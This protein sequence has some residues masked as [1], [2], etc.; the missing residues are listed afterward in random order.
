M[1]SPAMTEPEERALLDV[2]DLRVLDGEG[3]ELLS[4]LSFSLDAG[5]CLGIVGESG[6][7]KS[8]TALALCG[9][10]PAPL[11]ASGCL[12]LCNDDGAVSA[13]DLAGDLGKVR[14]GGIALVFQDALA[15]LHPLRR[16]G[17]QLRET[18]CVRR[19][20]SRTQA[21]VEA[22]QLLARMQ[23][24]DSVLSRLP[25]Q[26]SGGQRQRVLLALAL[27]TQPR[28]LIADESTSALDPQVQADVL[29]LLRREVLGRGIGL[30][31]IGHD[32]SVVASLADR[33]AVFHR[34]RLIEQGAAT[35]VLDHPTQ[36]YTRQL[37]AATRLPA[38]PPSVID[39]PLLSMRGLRVRY[40]GATQDALVLDALDIARGETLALVGESGSGK[41]TLARTLLR[42]LPPG[43]DAEIHLDG[44]RWDRLQGAALRRERRRV[45]SVFQD[46]YASLDPRQRIDRLLAEPRRIHGLSTD[47][48]TLVGLLAA[49]GLDAGAL[50]RHP[51]AF[52]GGQRQRI[53]IARALAA[54]PDLLI[55][56]EAVSALDARVR[57][58]ILAL[59]NRLKSERGLSLLF[60]SHDMD[61]A[62][63]VA[64]R[65]A[66][67]KDGRIVEC[68]P[69]PA[70][71]RSPRHDYSRALLAARPAPL[72]MVAG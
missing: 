14:G 60:I 5:R 38:A 51:H 31:F 41:S 69:A 55:A 48:D 58:E 12:N 2:R 6:S 19:G 67:M 59:L 17:S 40:P 10:L 20:Q 7:G 22:R 25:H 36:D 66:V 63:A 46:P 26:L 56:D 8:L 11:R 3:R 42:L 71:L 64:D 62:A 68:A 9:L 72:R 1:T 35:P 45:Q 65:I 15:S 57:G 39:S 34:G 32:L 70:L 28:L 52:S 61:A 21:D 44:L 53:A 23:L 47:R 50:G 29:A 13:F 24:P 27:A 43:L 49:V 4:S 30:V 33:L 37:I 54:E 18:L 16:I